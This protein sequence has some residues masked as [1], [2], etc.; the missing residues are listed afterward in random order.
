[1]KPFTILAIIVFSLVTVVHFLRLLFGWEV[2]INSIFIPL[3]ASAISCVVT[4][5]LA[6]MLWRENKK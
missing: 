3:W 5:V 4:T 6:I 2:Q 1:M